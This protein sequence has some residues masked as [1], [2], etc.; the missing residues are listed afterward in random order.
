MLQRL[1]RARGKTIMMVTHDARAV[2]RGTLA[3]RLDKGILQPFE[4]GVH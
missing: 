2:E 1:H 4:A 3:L